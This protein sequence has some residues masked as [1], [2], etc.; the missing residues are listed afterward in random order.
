MSRVNLSALIWSE[1]VARFAGPVGLH[2]PDL[3]IYQLRLSLMLAQMKV[4]TPSKLHLGQNNLIVAPNPSDQSS[5]SPVCYLLPFFLGLFHPIYPQ[6][7]SK[8]DFADCLIARQQRSLPLAWGQLCGM[9]KRWEDSGKMSPSTEILMDK[10]ALTAVPAS[11]FGARGA[12]L[13]GRGEKR[14]NKHTNLQERRQKDAS[15]PPSLSYPY[16]CPPPEQTI[17]RSFRTSLH[18]VY[19]QPKPSRRRI[20][21]AYSK[22]GI[23]TI[24]MRR[25]ETSPN[26]SLPDMKS[27]ASNMTTLFKQ[28]DYQTGETADG[29]KSTTALAE[30]THFGVARVKWDL[31]CVLQKYVH[32]GTK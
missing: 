28:P 19:F 16:L 32:T 5:L 9:R 26:T 14:Q 13:M 15:I 11:G 1:R 29:D 27:L 30:H 20:P 7:T 6:T 31:S 12:R 25:E 22:W 2:A 18:V 21:T 10:K 3:M 17:I 4:S 8:V 24:Q 23:N